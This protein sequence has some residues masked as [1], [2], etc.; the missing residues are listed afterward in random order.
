MR[1]LGVFLAMTNAASN[2]IRVNLPIVRRTWIWAR[3]W[4]R[5][6]A[7]RQAHRKAPRS[8]RNVGFKIKQHQHPS[9]R[10]VTVMASL[11]LALAAAP[12]TALAHGGAGGGGG[13]GGG[14]G[15][16][17]GAHGTAGPSSEHAGE[18]GRIDSRGGAAAGDHF[19]RRLGCCGWGSGLFDPFWGPYLWMD[20]DS[21][22]AYAY[23]APA[24]AFMAPVN[25]QLQPVT[26]YWY[27]CA[28][29]QT[30]YPYVRDCASAWLKVIPPPAR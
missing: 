3:P 22:D 17:G 13:G 10:I 21:G 7:K 19:Y 1:V 16:G 5:T 9:R 14:H 12:L 18:P 25:P 27:Y 2:V 15:G 29:S 23:A 4:G 8:S 24:A 20:Y 11:L 28:D 26:S 30:Y 6:D